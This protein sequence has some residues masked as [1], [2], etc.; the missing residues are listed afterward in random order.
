MVK[1]VENPIILVDGSFYLYR[2]YHAFPSLINSAGET[3]GAI[4]GVL[5]MLKSLLVQYQPSHV[6]VVFDAKGKTFRNRLFKDYKS[7]RSPMP[8]DLQNQITP[9]HD[10]IKAMGLPL[11]VVGDVEA[12]D[13]IGTLALSA[14]R[15]GHDVLISTGDKDMAQLVSSKITLTNAISNTIFGPEEIK[16]KFG[17][18]PELIID[19]LSLVG[20]NSDNIP[21][22]P[23]IGEKTALALL[24]GLGGLEVLYNQLDII[25]TLNFRG[26]KTIAIKLEKY[27]EVA[28][29][30]YQL[31][32]IKT[33]V[34]LDLTYDKLR[35]KKY[36]SEGL[37]LLFQRYE[38]KRWLSDLKVGK[39]LQEYKN[40]A[41]QPLLFSAPRL[42]PNKH[43]TKT[44]SKCSYIIINTISTLEMWI[45]AIRQAGFFAFNISTDRL[46]IFITNLIGLCFSIKPNEA[47]YLPIGHNYLN[48][49]S[50]LDCKTVLTALKPILEDPTITKISQNLKFDCRILKRYNI[51]LS[52]TLFDTMLES[53][54]LDS[55]AGRH[56]IESLS[57]RF[58]QYTIVNSNK[59]LGKNRNQLV[60]DQISIEQAALY[61]AEN[62]D[63]TLRLHQK[64]WPRINQIP[65]L[66]KI[67]EEIEIPLVPILLRIEQNG[68]LI[69]K[70]VLTAYS[71]ELKKCLEELKAKAHQLAEES[72][73]LSSIKQIRAIL[74]KKQK[75]PVLKKTPRGAPSS[76]EGVLTELASNY[77]LPKLIL[78]YRSLV[79]L[80][81]SYT[82]K[83]P[84][85]IHSFSNRIHTSYHQA[86]TSTGRLSSSN[87]NLQNIPAQNNTGQRIRKA[88]IAPPD[89]IIMTADYSQIELRIMAHLSRDPGLL[90][91]F[92]TETDIHCATA[93]EIFNI[94]LEKVTQNQRRSAK[95][96]NF[97]LIYGMSIFGLA[98]QLSVSP[99]DAKKY[100]N[101]YFD[102]YSGVLEYM[103]RIRKHARD[104]GYVE[105][106][107]GRRL[108]L[109]NIHS[110]NSVLKKSAE[111]AAIN[112]P[113]QGTAADII[114][115]AMIIID[116]W[117]QK[118]A[119]PIHMI[120]QVHDEIVFEVQRTILESAKIQIKELMESCFRLD[121]PLHVK[122]GIGENWSQAH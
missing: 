78:E 34:L 107:D 120:M 49:P 39:W 113:M 110:R 45:N 98:R 106:L 46:D 53:Y 28:F 63:I 70:S 114:K 17:V 118:E 6:A 89:K 80:K 112:A 75:L 103:E 55:V 90:N 86:I 25:S 108:Y 79:K 101:L 22:V 105:T 97:G 102:R 21:G 2:A 54:V 96:I 35:V 119:P 62:V 52:G 4:Y 19:Y 5:N 57:K 13:V 33:D 64:I 121:I 69:D 31:A 83:L 20:D 27:R 77:P 3:T 87:P 24:Q 88:F 58:L 30:S 26:A 94:P 117:L 74:Y 73:N 72:F 116:N 93:A 81:S 68:V 122:I 11:V 38:F 48:A 109:P 95:T 60:F 43:L 84:K 10:M 44:L 23:G 56:D 82:D 85:M 9:L 66:K 111:R 32:T 29:L 16:I 15:N 50:Q 104:L 51:N 40:T 8:D 14:A 7:N 12:D 65:N 115:R 36:E 18:P 1:I 61:S 99:S 76:N 71:V 41:V 100:M 59:I 92:A 67:F 37:M 42:V 47:A 91:A